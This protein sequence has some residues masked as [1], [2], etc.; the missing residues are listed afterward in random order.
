[1]ET[2][3]LYRLTKIAAS[4]AILCGLLYVVLGLAVNVAS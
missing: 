2:A 1:M 3:K 4:T